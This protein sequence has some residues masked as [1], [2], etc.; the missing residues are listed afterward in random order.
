MFKTLKE[1]VCKELK[2]KYKKQNMSTK[3]QIIKKPNV[4]SGVKMYN[5]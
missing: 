3:K 4:N 2:Y 5:K 1:T